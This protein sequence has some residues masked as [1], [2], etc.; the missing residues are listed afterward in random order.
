[1]QKDKITGDKEKKRINVRKILRLDE[2]INKPYTKV[3][4][5]LKNNFNI[6]EIREL[7]SINGDTEINFIIKDKNKEARY[8]LQ[9]NRKFDL[10]HLKALKAKEYV[11]KITV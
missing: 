6:E 7:L 9:N 8:S 3:T 11:A 4:I 5:E 1:M 2:V 10:E